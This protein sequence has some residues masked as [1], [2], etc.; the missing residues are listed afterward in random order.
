MVFFIECSK[1][2]PS[3]DKTLGPAAPYESIC[4]QSG[5]QF[6]VLFYLDTKL[7]ILKQQFCCYPA[8]LDKPIFFKLCLHR[9]LGI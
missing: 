7:Q 4:H 6:E 3:Q 1:G 2:D 5:V 9:I 8:E